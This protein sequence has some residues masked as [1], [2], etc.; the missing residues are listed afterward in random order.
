[1][2]GAGL[3]EHHLPSEG[4]PLWAAKLHLRSDGG[5]RSATSSVRTCPTELGL[6]HS[7]AATTGQLEAHAK[8]GLRCPNTL[9]PFLWTH[10][11]S[12]QITKRITAMDSISKRREWHVNAET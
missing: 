7:G 10:K 2:T 12:N 9:L 11:K 4:V 5:L 3:D 1:M 6:V 8:V